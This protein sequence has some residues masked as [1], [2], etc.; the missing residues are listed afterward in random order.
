MVRLNA[1]EMALIPTCKSRH[2]WRVD[3]WHHE[4]DRKTATH[5][6]RDRHCG[7]SS[8]GY[9]ISLRRKF[10]PLSSALMHNQISTRTVIPCLSFPLP[11]SLFVP[12][13][14]SLNGVWCGGTLALF[15]L[16]CQSGN[17]KKRNG[18]GTGDGTEIDE[19]MVFLHW[20]G[21]EAPVKVEKKIWI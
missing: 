20:C 2:W 11:C 21:M 15:L 13:I 7:F 17:R 1:T 14:V 3:S 16:L 19:G 10:F 4:T 5:P 8:H 18:G 12:L 6:Q 9:I